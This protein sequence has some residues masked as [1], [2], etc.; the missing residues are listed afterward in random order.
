M[1]VSM[2][3]PEYIHVQTKTIGLNLSQNNINNRF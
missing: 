3:E 2:F 1:I